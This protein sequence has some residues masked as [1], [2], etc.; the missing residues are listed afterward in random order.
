MEVDGKL[1][2]KTTALVPLEDTGCV[3]LAKSPGSGEKHMVYK[4]CQA[5][6]RSEADE[7]KPR[8]FWAAMWNTCVHASPGLTPYKTGSKSWMYDNFYPTVEKAVKGALK[9]GWEV[10]RM[11][12]D[13]LF[14]FGTPFDS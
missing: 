8:Y 13:D 10:K 7:K 1:H 5:P 2:Y 6:P 4:L 14:R 12:F 9:E 3:F 11:Y